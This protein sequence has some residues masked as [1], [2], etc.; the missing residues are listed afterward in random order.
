[1]GSM[2]TGGV[3]YATTERMVIRGSGRGGGVVGRITVIPEKIVYVTEPPQKDCLTIENKI[4]IKCIELK[5]EANEKCITI[6][7]DNPSLEVEPDIDPDGG[8][9]C[10]PSERPEFEIVAVNGETPILNENIDDTGKV[11]IKAWDTVTINVTNYDA[12]KTYDTPYTSLD[13]KFQ[14]DDGSDFFFD[15]GDGEFILTIDDTQ[16]D[17]VDIEIWVYVTDPDNGEQV[18]CRNISEKWVMV[19]TMDRSRQPILENP[20]IQFGENIVVDIR[21]YNQ[22]NEYTQLSSDLTNTDDY[23]S[24]ENGAILYTPPFDLFLD[25]NGDKIQQFI[26]LARSVEP[27]KKESYESSSVV[28]VEYISNGY[29]SIR[30]NS[31]AFEVLTTEEPCSYVYFFKLILQFDIEYM[32]FTS[33]H[34]S[35]SRLSIAQKGGVILG[36]PVLTLDLTSGGQCDTLIYKSSGV[37]SSNLTTENQLGEFVAHNPF[38]PKYSYCRS[39]S[40]NCFTRYLAGYTE[41]RDIYLANSQ[42][43][44]ML[45]N[46]FFGLGIYLEEDSTYYP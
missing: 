3:T 35:F 4:D 6:E 39:G 36:V 7:I 28:T 40:S 42:L 10:E 11:Y 45:V 25:S 46:T 23:L 33:S 20:T 34:T 15:N 8:V 17:G 32:K 2:S 41:I 27:L 12:N 44:T 13:N 16:L 30:P 18:F 24:I 22:D 19:Q 5:A 38:S 37:Y 14:E 26:I 43:H 31:G 9:A 21:N 1:M 29:V